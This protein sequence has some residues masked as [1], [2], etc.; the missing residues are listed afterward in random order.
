MS[1]LSAPYFHDEQAAYNFVE[2]RIWPDG[3]TCPRCGGTNRIGQMGGNSTRIGTYKCYVCRKPFT[4]KIGTIFES[5]HIPLHEWLQAI[6]LM[7]SSKKGI[8]SN[9][10][11]RTLG[12]TLKSAWFLSH[13]IRE[14][15][16]D[17]NVRQMGGPGQV[18][19]V[20][21]TFVGRDKSR[22]VGAGWMHKL[23]VV[24]LVTRDGDAR[25]FHVARIDAKTILPI[26]HA[27][28]AKD[29]HIMTDDAGHYR[30]LNQWYKHDTISH[31]K[32]E[33][34][35]GIIHTNTIEGFFSIFKRGMR[36]VYQHCAKKHLHRYLAEFDFRYTNRIA[37]GVDDFER[38]VIAL[39]GVRGKR[40][41][42][43]TTNSAKA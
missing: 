9:Q 2:A 43:Q 1:I 38:T 13:R 32:G 18:V 27:N 16:R 19:E 35:F 23:K 22:K 15:M 14:A 6:F 21:E 20:D 25:S 31:E 37:Q 41:M 3:P 11:H 42:Y 30:K 5:S 28:I 34:G 7:C 36:G 12:V 4:V 17:D 33:Y 10:L 39:L 29:S 8:S 26:I 40:L 24:S